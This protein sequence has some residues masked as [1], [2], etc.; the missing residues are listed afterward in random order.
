VLVAEAQPALVEFLSAC[1]A[2]AASGG[3]EPRITSSPPHAEQILQ[4]CSSTTY[5]LVIVLLNNLIFPEIGRGTPEARRARWLRFIT[6]LKCLNQGA[7]VALCGWMQD[8][9]V[10]DMLHVTD[11]IAAGADFFFVIP[12]QSAE[13]VGAMKQCLSGTARRTM[14]D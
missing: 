4:R 2:S 13:L 11:A 7:I 12:A 9:P 1:V 3:C 10:L 6:E 8:D 5:D 14:L